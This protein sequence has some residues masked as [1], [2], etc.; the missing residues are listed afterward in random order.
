MTDVKNIIL[1]APIEYGYLGI[2]RRMKL[3]LRDLDL[4]DKC[5]LDVGCGNGAQTIEFTNL[6]KNVIGVDKEQRRLDEFREICQTSG[7]RN[8]EIK[9]MN[10]ENLQ[11]EDE[12]F[13]IV[14]CIETLEHIPNQ[15]KALSEMY[16]VLRSR[17]SLILSV[18]NRWWI[19]E[20]H[21]ANLPLLKWNRFPFFSW[22]PKKIHDKYAYGR[23]YTKKEIVKLVRS[24]GFKDIETEYLMPPLDKLGNRFLRKALRKLLFSLERTPLKIFGVSMFV[25]GRK[26]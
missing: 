26:S 15:G 11:F 6:C 16:R 23:I 1:G 13:D 22:A 12:S 10:A 17:G 2:K 18:P 4:T 8:C 21:G 5:L 14:S 7:L 19:F 24:F 20:T 9:Q 3:I 25:F